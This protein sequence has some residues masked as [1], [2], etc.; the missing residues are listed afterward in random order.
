MLALS[1]VLFTNLKVRAISNKIQP[2]T[3]TVFNKDSFCMN[4]PNG[5]RLR[6]LKVIGY[7]VYTIGC[8]SRVVAGKICLDPK[9]FFKEEAHFILHFVNHD[10]SI[11]P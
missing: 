4:S 3:T 7:N 10:P 9:L 2:Q 8:L 11:V 5:E 6:L 1:V